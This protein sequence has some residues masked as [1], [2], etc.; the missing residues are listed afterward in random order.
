[1]RAALDISSWKKYLRED[2]QMEMCTDTEKMTES[3][4]MNVELGS[5]KR[6]VDSHHWNLESICKMSQWDPRHINRK[7]RDGY[8]VLGFAQVVRLW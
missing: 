5:Y 3:A 8:K 2:R 4:E 7:L 6:R 1:M